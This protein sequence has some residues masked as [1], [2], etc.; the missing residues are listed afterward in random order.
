MARLVFRGGTAVLDS[1]YRIDY[2]L[3]RVEVNA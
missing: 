3:A 1:M 2:S